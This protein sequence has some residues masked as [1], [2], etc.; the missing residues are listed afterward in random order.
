MKTNLT[1]K[2]LSLVLLCVNAVF[3]VFFLTWTILTLANVTLFGL[4]HIILAAVVAFLNL[5]YFV[6]VA[7]TLCLNKK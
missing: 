4:L 1:F 5:S 2:I 6:Y 7:I 3:V